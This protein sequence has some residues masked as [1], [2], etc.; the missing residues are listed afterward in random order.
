M[1][2]PALHWRMLPPVYISNPSI[3]ALMDAIYTAGIST[4]YAD[5]TTRTPG[6]FASPGTASL[7]ASLGT[8]SAWTWNYDATTFATGQ[9]TACYAYAPTTT[10]INQALIV[11][12][13]TNVTGA[14]W[15]Q[16]N[17]DSRSAT[18]PFVGLAKNSGV[19]TSWNNATTPFTSGDFTGFG[20]FGLPAQNYNT[21]FM[22]ESEEAVIVQIVNAA[23]GV[24]G[25]VAGAAV[26]PLSVNVANAE[27]DGRLYG[28]AST[29]ASNNMGALW[30]SSNSSATAPL[31]AQS[32]TANDVHSNTFTPGAGTLTATWRFGTFAPGVGFTSRNGDLP[33]IPFQIWDGSSKYMG[34][35]RQMYITRDGYTGVGWQVGSTS[36]GY[37]LGYT[38]AGSIGDCVLL[39]Y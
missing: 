31:F 10:A 3:S 35:L 21:L 14:N 8:G 37:L 16:T 36:K 19:Y 28:V 22:W 11:A 4:V 39:A 1:A 2:L 18:Y 6:T 13:T 38:T 9:K 29:G 20:I 7:P 15:K 12:G 25:F 27:T 33:E 34:Q 26:D 24:S 32:A 5:G 17:T 30:L 23:G